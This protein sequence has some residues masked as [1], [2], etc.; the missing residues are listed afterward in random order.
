MENNA[1]EKNIRKNIPNYIRFQ[2]FKRDK[3]TCQ[4]CGRSGVELE[5]DHIKPI[6]HGGTND[7][8]NLI[9]ACKA[10]NRGKSDS[11][12]LP[13][14]YMVERESKSRRVQLLIRPSVYKGIK[15]IAASKN[16]SVN[17]FV[18]SLFER[19]VYQEGEE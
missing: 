3:F 2:V 11:L 15:K 13:D 5:V 9:T 6:A 10:C 16:M 12:V 19:E 14:G 17:E 4:Y 1:K 8:D 18:N 7:I